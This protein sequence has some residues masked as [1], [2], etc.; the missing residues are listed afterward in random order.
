MGRSL[1]FYLNRPIRNEEIAALITV[2]RHDG[3]TGMATPAHKIMR[4]A[5][6]RFRNEYPDREL[7]L[8][9]RKR[10][11]RQWM[12]GAHLFA[13]N[14]QRGEAARYAARAALWTLA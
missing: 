1:S 13:G 5:F 2:W 11:A 4:E 7:Q 6:A 14:G 12:E 9:A 3:A 8:C 10:V